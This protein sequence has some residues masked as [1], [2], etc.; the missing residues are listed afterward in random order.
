MGFK[1]G[2]DA[3]VVFSN[4]LLLDWMLEDSMNEVCNLTALYIFYILFSYYN[5]INFAK[6]DDIS[7][8][9]EFSVILYL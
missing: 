9:L 4:S 3:H 2:M 5:H 1:M 8:I 7:V 6:C